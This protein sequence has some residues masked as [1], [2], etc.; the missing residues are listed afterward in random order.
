MAVTMSRVQ[1]DEIL[2]AVYDDLRSIASQAL[3]RE[4][5]D[6]TFQTTELVHEIYLKLAGIRELDWS[7]SDQLLRAAVGIVRRI[8]IDYARA[9]KATKRVPDGSAAFENPL[10]YHDE[11][12]ISAPPDL[13]ELEEALERLHALDPRKSEVV[14]LRYFGGQDVETVARLL[15]ISP[16]TVKREWA[17][18]KAWLYRELS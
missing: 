9:K 1:L 13:L 15:Q 11:N 5:S 4:S 18:A 8:L 17:L 12:G 14:H 7:D 16:T 6:H 2:P 3:K 10:C